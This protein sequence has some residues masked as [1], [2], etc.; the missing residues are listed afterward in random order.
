MSDAPQE[1]IEDFDPLSDGFGFT[2]RW[3][4]RNDSWMDFE[5]F[6]VAGI[7]GDEGG[8]KLYDRKDWQ[9]SGDEVAS[10]DDAQVYCSGYIKWDGCAEIDFGSHHFCGARCFKKH[11][12][13]M[14]WLYVRTYE[15]LGR[16]P[17]DPW[18]EQP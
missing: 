6:E 15:L 16:D 14:K 1:K 8:T 13:L 4:W 2:V 12:A 11:I 7:E 3:R 5:T 18:K 17:L 10:I 9:K